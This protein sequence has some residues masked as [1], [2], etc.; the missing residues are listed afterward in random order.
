MMHLHILKVLGSV[1]SLD[2]LDKNREGIDFGTALVVAT[3]AASCD[4]RN[5]NFFGFGFGFELSLVTAFPSSSV[6][7]PACSPLL[8]IRDRG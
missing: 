7:P 3:P 1:L 2:R 5:N 6:L 4:L 8:R